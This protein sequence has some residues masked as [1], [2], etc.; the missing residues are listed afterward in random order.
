MVMRVVRRVAST[1]R[2]L[3]T[4]VHQPSA[5]IFHLFDDLLL[6]QRGGWMAFVGPLGDGGAALIRHLSAVPG[7]HPCP[8]GMNPASW[9]LDVLAGTDSRRQAGVSA[10]MHAIAMAERGDGL[11]G[12]A[13]K[14]RLLSSEQWG[15]CAKALDAACSSS[16]GASPSTLDD[17]LAHSF[18]AQTAVLLARGARSYARSL[19]FVFQRIKALT[20]L[21]LLFA[22]VWYK[23]QQAVDCAPAQD[24]DSFVCNNTPQGVQNVVGIIFITSLF[25]SVVSV[26]ALLPYQLRARAVFYRER[27]SKLYGPEAYGVAGTLIE[28]PWLFVT[29]VLAV[30][31]LYFSVG[32]T[33]TAASYFFYIFITWLTMLCFVG[34]GQ[35]FAAYFNNGATAQSV[36]SL[37]L[38]MAALFG[39]VYMPKMQLPDGARNGHPGVYWLWAYHIDP[40]SHAL[41]ALSAARFA[42]AGR[43]ST[44]GHVIMVPSGTGFELVDALQYVQN[45]RGSVYDERWKQVGYLIAI[46]GGMQLCHLYALRVKV[47]VTR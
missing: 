19:G 40:V 46:A 1:G 38:P 7:A 32:F 12:A 2:T 36:I 17:R 28:L 6:M 42:D 26:S 13:L 5:E 33:N 27:A 10:K 22:A 30:T 4:T 18:A 34:L 29:A 25:T 45:T 8:P 16:P 47:H 23:A 9:M 24:A 44:V 43:P 21:N 11:E 39:G 35:W 20:M 41:E 14:E 31:P 37:V 15:P 3:V